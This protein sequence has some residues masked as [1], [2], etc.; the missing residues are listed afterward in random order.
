[1]NDSPA[2]L[3]QRLIGGRNALAQQFAAG[4]PARRLLRA[5]TRLI[6]ETLIDAWRSAQIREHAALVAVGGYGR[7]ELFP[8]SDIDLLILLPEQAGEATLSAVESLVTQFWDIGLEVGHSVR[9]VAECLT[10]AKRDVTVHTT[11]LEARLLV[12]S[13]ILF[14]DLTKAIAGLD[15]RAFFDAKILEQQQRHGRFFD[16][17]YNLEPNLKESPGSLRD[18]QTVAWISRALGL[19]MTWP[20]LVEAGLLLPAEAR[21]MVAHENFLIALRAK[22][23][24]LAGRREDRLLFDFQTALAER[25][26]FAD[27]PHRR[28]SEML[29]QRY[30]R[31]A[32]SIGLMTEIMLQNL[33]AYITPPEGDAIRIDD[34]FVARGNLLETRDEQTFERSPQS[35]LRIF[36]VL[37]Q[38][39]ELTGI[40][41][42][43]LRALARAVRRID[44]AYRRAPEHR[45][46]FVEI[47]RQPQGLTH[48]LRRMHRY[49]VL[50]KYL[51]S[52]GAIVGQMQHDLFHA[53]TVDEHIL[54]VIRN[55]RRFAQ[56]EFAHEFPLCSELINSFARPETLYFSA[57]FHDIAKGRGGD[58]SELGKA[59]ARQFCRDHKL[60]SEDTELIVWLVENHLHMSATAQKK[61]LS[62]PEVIADFAR[63]VK[64]ERR[65]T[66]LYL[67]T[68]ADIRGTSPKVWNA[69]KGKLLEDL[70]RLTRRVLTHSYQL[71]TLVEERKR[72]ARGV[73]SAYP[74]S[75][76]RIDE[77]WAL[78]EPGH[79]LRYEAPEIALQTRLLYSHA[80]T[81]NAIVR[82]HLSPYGD[83]IQVL[84]YTPDRGQLFAQI[85]GFFEKIDYTIVEAKVSTTRRGYA[86]DTFL[87]MNEKEK[88][89]RYRDLLNLIETQLSGRLNSPPPLEPPLRGRV[90]RHLK[91][92]PIVPEVS[93]RPDERNQYHVLSITAGDR[94]GLLSTI[95]Q[96]LL[97]HDI[98][99]HTAKITTLG[100]RAE[101]TFLVTGDALENAK[102]AL[103]FEADL[104]HALE[105]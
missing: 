18:L 40:G 90:S 103:R 89:Y 19:G 59:D 25:M 23:H 7:R 60:G 46:L 92:F 77:F 71:D 56:T 82:A 6:D 45:Q 11:L 33:R 44:S 55:L 47:F 27:T 78:L 41:A 10:E 17:A 39:A 62:D 66:A 49:G 50:G 105:T 29:M 61:D 84:I 48:A 58:H 67:V 15:A 91:H 80:E 20:Q 95:A 13:R 73:L 68:V 83:G 42:T 87:I 2:A 32:K 12:G 97:R 43:T 52:F 94:P 76:A 36:L 37:Q 69:W 24:Y 28:T 96:T 54:F 5:T 79:F 100:E 57:L 35:I 104:L 65:L 9:S 93:I 98:A 3:R 75:E 64:D 14:D 88:L 22:L 85:C 86:L 74:I 4:L 81:R 102:A 72:A 101:D 21:H 8:H 34:D 38:H 16:T 63:R 30:Y 1:M 51:P 70:Y 53:Y 31:T 26:G 99:L